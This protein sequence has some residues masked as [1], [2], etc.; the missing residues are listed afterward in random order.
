MRT[1]ATKAWVATL[2]SAL[3]LACSSPPR[4]FASDPGAS[5]V[6]G[7][8][9]ST[10]S[11]ASGDD[12][13][14]G[15]IGA[16]TVTP[17]NTGGDSGPPPSSGSMASASAGQ[18]DAGVIAASDVG[19]TVTLT[20]QS[21]TVQPGAEVYMCQKIANPFP[22]EADLIWMQGKMSEGSHHFFLYTLDPI[23]A[24]G[25]STTISPCPNGGVESHP[26]PFV[27]Q[28]P[29]WTVQYPPAPDGSPMGY[30]LQ[31]TDSLMINTHYL[32]AS[33]TAIQ[34]TASIT[35]EAA[36][37]GIVKTHVGVIFLSSQSITVPASATMSNPSISS[38]TWGGN[39]KA[40]S[41]D[42]SYTIFTSWTHMH[43]WG[44]QLSATTDNHVF[45]TESNWNEPGFYWHMP[46]YTSSPTATGDT[47][48]VKMTASQGISWGCKYYNDTGK[49]LTFGE[50]AQ[51][52]VMC[53]YSAQYYPA[54]ATSPDILFSN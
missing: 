17:V 51:T 33:A 47:S 10:G 4:G 22:G 35:I 12:A 8:D 6:S 25:Y 28:A 38:N 31:A 21:F 27:S 14:T 2:G 29:L 49:K 45:Y 39:A 44:L 54:S 16:A 41:D 23:T 43:H 36:K 20:S 13:S 52:N 3:L 40:A 24:A 53:I 30:P 11:A 18:Q 34:A 19:Q 9:G 46:G 26:F 32:N 15:G 7:D 42:G 37:P 48:P 50:S 5:S 1:T